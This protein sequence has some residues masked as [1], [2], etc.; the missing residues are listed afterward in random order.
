M[1]GRFSAVVSTRWSLQAGHFIENSKFGRLTCCCAVY[2]KL[3]SFCLRYIVSA[4]RAERAAFM[5]GCRATAS[6]SATRAVA[7]SP[8]SI[9]TKPSDKANAARTGGG[10]ALAYA[11]PLEF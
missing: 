2:Y 1:K 7:L 6:L 11:D 8:R 5:S 3:V 9:A 10:A 4:A